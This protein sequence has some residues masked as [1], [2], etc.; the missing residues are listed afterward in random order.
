MP[1]STKHANLVI[2]GEDDSESSSTDGLRVSMEYTGGRGIKVDNNT[3]LEYQTVPMSRNQ[4]LQIALKH[5][6]AGNES[7][8]NM[9][10]KAAKLLGHVPSNQPSQA[11]FD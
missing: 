8:F 7:K 1:N 10:F 9:Y 11:N 5:A 6:D 2:I 4:Y 3:N